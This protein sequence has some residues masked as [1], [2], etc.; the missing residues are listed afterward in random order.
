LPENYYSTRIRYKLR[1]V[2]GGTLGYEEI[3][4]PI[5]PDF[6]LPY[7]WESPYVPTVLPTVGSKDYLRPGYS[8]KPVVAHCAPYPYLGERINQCLSCQKNLLHTW[9]ILVIVKHVCSTFRRQKR[10]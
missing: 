6:P 10:H 9:I 4:G 3:F 5:R 8:R 7:P 2:A 1:R